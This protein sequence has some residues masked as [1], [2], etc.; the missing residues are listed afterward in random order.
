MHLRVAAFIIWFLWGAIFSG[1]AGEILIGAGATFPYPL[2]KKWISEYQKS[3]DARITYSAVGSG[4]GIGQVM[5]KSVDF[6]ATDVSL[7]EEEIIKLPA[8]IV[9]I[10]TCV[11]AVVVP[12]N[13]PNN[14]QLNLTPSTLADIFLGRI[15]IWN[16]KQLMEVNPGINLPALDIVVIHRSDP[17]GTSYQFT[18]YLNR[19]SR[20]WS[21]TCGAGKEV[22]WPV[23]MGV[24][25]N[26]RIVDMIQHVPGSI[27][28]TEMTYASEKGLV[29]ASLRNESG[30][31]IQPTLESI[32]IG[33]AESE[34][35]KCHTNDAPSVS[36]GYP[37]AGFSYVVVYKEQAYDGRSRDRATNLA[38]LLWWMVHEGQS[39]NNGLLYGTLPAYHVVQA[40]ALIRSMTYEGKPLADW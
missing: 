19:I 10:P 22:R 38:K 37:I 25:G 24:D 39:F 28:Y 40:K 26:S 29:M 1:Y 17:S 30:T 3:A 5:E 18:R 34:E 13:L 23:G 2:Y 32:S 16:D 27:G 12:Y 21:E 7:S 33:I 20:E 35:L 31:F 15:R 9:H 14:P 36:K 8:E 4:K 6:G 11:G